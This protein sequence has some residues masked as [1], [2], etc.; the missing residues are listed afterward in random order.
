LS[1]A[2]QTACHVALVLRINKSHFVAELPQL[3]SLH[4]Q[5]HFGLLCPVSPARFL[6]AWF[7]Y[8]NGSFGPPTV[9][10]VALV[11]RNNKTQF[12]AELPQ[13]HSLH[14]PSS[15]EVPCCQISLVPA[16][17]TSVPEAQ[18]HQCLTAVFG[19]LIVCLAADLRFKKPS[20]QFLGLFAV[21]PQAI[22]LYA[23]LCKDE[24]CPIC[25]DIRQSQVKLFTSST[26]AKSSIKQIWLYESMMST[27]EEGCTKLNGLNC[28]A[29]A[30]T[31][32]CLL[33]CVRVEWLACT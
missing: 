5:S 18:S 17:S 24:H 9:C 11:L 14:G 31:E 2:A 13:R 29:W 30:M 1:F 3:V 8:F 20:V 6:V 23:P 32:C 16:P 26:P 33:V 10:I 4:A 15:L 7:Q 27:L 25:S 19:A 22:S 21:T 12:V 28:D